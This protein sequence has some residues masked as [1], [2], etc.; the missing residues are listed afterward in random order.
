MRS[1]VTV[2]V[3]ARAWLAL[4][5]S[6]APCALWIWL[7][8]RPELNSTLLLPSE[9]FLV[10]TLV[11]VMA[12]G[13]AFLV[14]R[15]A[16]VME[17]YQ[18][19]LIALGFLS[20]AGFFAVHAL[21][22]PG[23]HTSTMADPYGYTTT[24]APVSFDY[25]GTLIGASAFLSLS[26]PA[27][28]FAAGSSQPVLE[29][30]RRHV[31]SRWLTL[32]AVA[33]PLAYAGVAAWRADLVA[34]LPLSRPPL[35][36]ALLLASGVLLAYAA[37]RQGRAYATS[38]FPVSGALTMAFVVLIQA[39]VLVVVSGFWTLAWWGYH[40]LMLAGVVIALAA[41]FLE[42]DRR[43]G[44]ERFLSRELVE[45]V[46]AG[47]LLRIAGERRTVSL[48]F[49][50]LRGSTT[51]AESLAPEDVIAIVNAYVGE[52]ARSVFAHDGMLDKFLGDGLMAIF[53]VLP[54]PSCGAVPAARAALE[55][56]ER[57]LRMNAE[58]RAHGQITLDFG[59]AVH[60]GEVVL[61]AVGIAQR[62][63]FTAIGDTV[64][65][66]ARLEGQC[67][68]LGL[69][70]VLSGQTAAHLPRSEFHVVDLAEVSIRGRQQ[71]V[72]VA[73]LAID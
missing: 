19:L 2:T 65:T 6:V 39:Q 73:T 28:F 11:S 51:L 58:R 40:V 22:T 37:W 29:L 15:T 8:A 57:I 69:D 23:A 59:V 24:A 72:A 44:L 53:G 31:P 41:L 27:V 56:R 71:P 7:L 10:V 4:S 13:V 33:L 67:K 30:L 36:Y 68:E 12:V 47:D 17:Q 32:A 45:R 5:L 21:A 55:M 42:L 14:V 60:T 9:H 49:A 3:S 43:R 26:I 20:M 61:G 62:S 34:N 46:V 66:A 48:L 38:H 18:V 50:D 25:N 52:L 54:D 16:L 64:N 70:I 35:V 63:D 1:T